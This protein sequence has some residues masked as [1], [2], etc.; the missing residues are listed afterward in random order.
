MAVPVIYCQRKWLEDLFQKGPENLPLPKLK[1]LTMGPFK[2]QP[3]PGLCSVR[4]GAS[5]FAIWTSLE[6][7][8]S[9]HYGCKHVTCVLHFQTNV[10]DSR[11]CT[12]VWWCRWCWAVLIPT[13]E[14]SRVQLASVLRWP[15]VNVLFRAQPGNICQC[16]GPN[17]PRKA[18]SP[19]ST[20]HKI[21]SLI[22]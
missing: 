17:I 22:F 18:H 8:V 13:L 1:N 11:W 21:A 14:L 9:G 16:N 4:A 6:P 5:T 7:K 20:V 19:S 15:N 10:P 12:D 2:P 3:E